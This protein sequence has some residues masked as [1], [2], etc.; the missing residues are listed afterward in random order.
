MKPLVS[1][2]TPS[3]NQGK[4]IR[5]TIESVLRQDYGFIEYIVVDGGS[6]DQTLDILKEYEGEISYISEKDEG[7][8]N[9]INKGFRM[10]RG[11]IVAWL[12]SDDLYEPGAVSEAV[13]LLQ[14]NPDVALVYGNGYIID[15]NGNKV[16]PFEYTA[17]FNM[18]EL[19]HVWDYIMQPTTFFRRSALCEVG[20]LDESLHWTMDWDLWIKLALRF[21]VQYSPNFWACSR[22]YGETKTNTGSLERLKEIKALTTKY[23]GENMVYGYDI[24]FY[25]EY[26]RQNAE[27][28]S[29]RDEYHDKA[30]E[31][32]LR[33]PT[34]NAQGRCG[35]TVYFA[36]KQSTRKVWIEIINEKTTEVTVGMFYN[37][38]FSVFYAST[39]G[40]YIVPLELA[41]TKSKFKSV[42]IEFSN[43]FSENTEERSQ[44]K[45]ICRMLKEEPTNLS[46]YGVIDTYKKEQ[47]FFS[48]KTRETIN[49]CSKKIE[50]ERLML[51]PLLRKG[52]IYDF[53]DASES[54]HFLWKSW[55]ELETQGR[56]SKESGTLGFRIREKRSQQICICYSTLGEL[57]HVQVYY[58]DKYIGM[59]P[60][61]V[62]CEAV[63]AI[64]GSKYFFRSSF[65]TLKFVVPNAYALKD[66]REG[67]DHR[68]LG[69]MLQSICFK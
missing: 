32:I 21:D 39:P 18:W 26:A 63:L 66:R 36:V 6:T 37:G 9:A 67:D 23:S 1:V 31:I 53:S 54:T 62:N 5:A 55:H 38:R 24:Y 64:K 40:K 10:A 4:F 59:L 56:W 14:K 41:D 58:D 47:R 34:P 57:N 52:K 29:L 2:I 51:R 13:E 43:P 28:I 35:K 11:E 68:V 65:H 48:G 12:N 17:P 8:S 7:Q 69:V 45:V 46:E 3:Y 20:Y 15:I 30:M 60:S 33:C 61:G 22:E 50:R 25:S 16:K 44:S 27:N 19:I 49:R 42:K